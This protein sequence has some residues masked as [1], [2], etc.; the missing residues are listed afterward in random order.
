MQ[1]GILNGITNSLNFFIARRIF[2]V[3]PPGTARKETALALGEY[4]NWSAISVGDLL[5]KE[6]SKK[7]DLGKEISE[8]YKN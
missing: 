4:F 2:L 1:I 5:N 7:S 3:G 8:S 6:V